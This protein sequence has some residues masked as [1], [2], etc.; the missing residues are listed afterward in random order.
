MSK[1]DSNPF[2]EDILIEDT[3]EQEG[4]NTQPK[5]SR[6][7]VPQFKLENILLKIQ[8]I[9]LTSPKQKFMTLIL[10]LGIITVLYLGLILVSTNDQKQARQELE[11]SPETQTQT[12]NKI[13]SALAKSVEEYNTRL[14]NLDNYQKELGQPIVDLDISFK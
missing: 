2:E 13:L 10:V 1:N 8:K 12:E 7:K 6:I 3:S 9:A 14:E 5:K 11:P 4:A